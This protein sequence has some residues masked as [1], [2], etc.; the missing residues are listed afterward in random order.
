MLPKYILGFLF[1]LIHSNELIIK[2]SIIKGNCH[3]TTHPEHYMDGILWHWTFRHF[4]WLPLVRIVHCLLNELKLSHRTHQQAL[5][6]LR[7]EK[8]ERRWFGQC[9]NKYFWTSETCLCTKSYVVEL[10]LLEISYTNESDWVL[11]TM[12]SYWVFIM[13]YLI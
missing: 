13:S 3:D 2:W 5:F 12:F 11:Q 6:M 1:Y 10:C 7:G 9:L 8:C 4:N